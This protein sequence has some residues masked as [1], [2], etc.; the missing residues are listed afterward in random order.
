MRVQL[1]SPAPLTGEPDEALRR[2]PARSGLL[3]RPRQVPA[4]SLRL[5]PRPRSSPRPAAAQDQRPPGGP[6]GDRSRAARPGRVVQ[7][8]AVA[9]VDRAR[10]WYRRG[11]ACN[12]LLWLHLP[13]WRRRSAHSPETRGV[14]DRYL[15]TAP[16]GL[17]VYVG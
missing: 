2:P 5:H 13:L 9:Q 11:R 8:A 4:G 10:L 6:E 7:L 16:P 12:S 17:L 3:P 1:S 15:T 14:Q